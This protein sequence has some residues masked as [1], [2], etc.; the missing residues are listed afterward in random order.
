MAINSLADKA[1][2]QAGTGHWWMQRV[3]AVVLVPLTFWLIALLDLCFTAPF[4]ETVTWLVQPFNTACIVSWITIAF[5]HAAL[6]L[7][8]VIEDYVAN[9]GMKKAGIWT[10]NLVFGFMALVALLAVFRIILKG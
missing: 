1:S 2:A 3:T 9:D 8:V 5:Y 4:Q 10:V 7:Q 6:G